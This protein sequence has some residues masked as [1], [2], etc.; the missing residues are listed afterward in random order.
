MATSAQEHEDVRFG[1]GCAR[2]V[3]DLCIQAVPAPR[4]TPVIGAGAWMTNMRGGRAG[5]LLRNRSYDDLLAATR[6]AGKSGGERAPKAGSF[7]HH[8]KRARGVLR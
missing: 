5:P 3:A 4:P 8:L 6:E 7:G 2:S 1:S